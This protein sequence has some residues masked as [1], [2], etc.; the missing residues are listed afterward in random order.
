MNAGDRMSD[1]LARAPEVRLEEMGSNG[2]LA[3]VRPP[4]TPSPGPIRAGRHYVDRKQGVMPVGETN[5]Q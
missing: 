3:A 1:L 5:A 4:R 2:V